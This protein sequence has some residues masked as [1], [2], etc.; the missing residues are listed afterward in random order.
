MVLQGQ[1]RDGALGDGE[2]AAI[3]VALSRDE[4]KA[5][6]TAAELAV[7]VLLPIVYVRLGQFNK[8]VLNLLHRVVS[9][10][11]CYDRYD[12]VRL[13]RILKYLP[14]RSVYMKIIRLYMT[15]K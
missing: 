10:Y 11:H 5:I 14:E 9:L 4:V 2:D 7:C 6:I 8:F 15:F 3:V 13:E 1:A 12:L